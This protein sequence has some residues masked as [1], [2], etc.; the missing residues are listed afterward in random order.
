MTTLQTI[1]PLAD[2]GALRLTTARWFT[3]NGRS[4]EGH[5]LIPDTEIA[6]EEDSQRTPGD[7][8]RDVQ[9]RRAIDVVEAAGSR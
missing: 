2:G 3:P 1:I 8:R 6:P 9:L 7:P 4:L 5:G